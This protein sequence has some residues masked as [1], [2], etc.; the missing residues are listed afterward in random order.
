MSF[1]FYGGLI[2]LELLQREGAPLEQAENVAEAIIRHQDLGDE[3]TITRVGALLQ[4]A[5]IFGK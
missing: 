5:T 2:V 1:E 4:I 3:G